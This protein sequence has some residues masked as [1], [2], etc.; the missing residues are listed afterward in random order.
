MPGQ[1]FD[2]EGLYLVC[3]T[4]GAAYA[5]DTGA[6]AGGPCNGRGL[7]PVAVEE[8]DGYVFLKADPKILNLKAD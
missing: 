4:H 2:S 1:F 5:P 6:C 3:A 7:Q 8:H